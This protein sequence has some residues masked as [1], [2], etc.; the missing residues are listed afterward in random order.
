MAITDKSIVYKNWEDS[1][2]SE[3]TKKESSISKACYTVNG[4]LINIDVEDSSENTVT[5]ASANVGFP[6][7]E[8]IAAIGHRPYTGDLE[9]IRFLRKEK[10]VKGNEEKNDKGE[11]CRKCGHF[12]E[13]Q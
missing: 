4:S 10:S 13:H 5:I 1:D 9:P 12:S 7:S 2:N 8:T 11:F 3:A 6:R